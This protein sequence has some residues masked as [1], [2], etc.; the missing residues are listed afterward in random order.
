MSGRDHRPRILLTAGPTHEPIDRVRFLGNRS[1]G[2]MG[3]AL[4][5][6]ARRFGFPVTLLLG[7]IGYEP[8]LPPEIGLKRFTTAD[9]LCRLLES[10]WSE[11]DM[12]VMAAA[13]SDFA[14]D[15]SQQLAGKRPRNSDGLD[16]HL[17]PTPDLVATMASISRPDQHVSGF[18][19]QESSDLEQQASRKLVQKKLDAIVANSL[20]TMDSDQVHEGTILLAD[21]TRLAP[22]SSGPMDKDS[23]SSWVL[24]TL[25]EDWRRKTKSP[26]NPSA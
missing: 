8:D 21:G 23:F 3:L 4:A 5:D 6:S 7:P 19:L 26:S 18:A 13:V 17:V 14:M 1:S 22:S 12:L 9:Q 10:C 2:K 20:D 11:H 25:V 24:Q 16:L 15:P